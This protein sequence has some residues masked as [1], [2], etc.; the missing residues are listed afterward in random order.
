[1]NFIFYDLE[2]T[3]IDTAFDQILQFAAVLT[4]DHLNILDQFEIRSRINPHI[5]P[6][7]AA[8]LVTGTSVHQLTDPNLPSHYQ[9]VQAIRKKLLDWSPAIFLGYNSLQFDEHLLRQALYQ[10]LHPPI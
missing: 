5:V 9:M 1:M 7:P 3:G 4:D 6:A 8:M 2:T 10:T